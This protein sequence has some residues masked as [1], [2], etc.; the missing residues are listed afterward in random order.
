MLKLSRAVLMLQNKAN[1]TNIYA[2]VAPFKASRAGWK[3][4]G[5]HGQLHTTQVLGLCPSLACRMGYSCIS[6]EQSL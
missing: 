3:T 5:H 2:P 1:V 4:S 6:T